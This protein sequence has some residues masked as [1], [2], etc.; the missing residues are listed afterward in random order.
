MKYQNYTAHG[1]H[2]YTHTDEEKT[3]KITINNSAHTHIVSMHVQLFGARI[4][5]IAK[6]CEC[7]KQN[8]EKKKLVS[9]RGQNESNDRERDWEENNKNIY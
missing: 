3:T 8:R 2:A 6:V 4:Q 9:L 5:N 7:S 1:P